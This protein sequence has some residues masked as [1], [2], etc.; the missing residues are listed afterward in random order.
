M[1]LIL[2]TCGFHICKFANSVKFTFNP[3]VNTSSAFLVIHGHAHEQSDKRI[4][5]Y[6]SSHTVNI[7]YLFRGVFRVAFLHFCAFY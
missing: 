2:I 7:L 1:E 4:E 3:Q 6:F 5:N